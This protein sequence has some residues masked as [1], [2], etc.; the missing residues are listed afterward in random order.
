MIDKRILAQVVPKS[1]MS[2]HFIQQQSWI[3]DIVLNQA[4]TTT[5]FAD[6]LVQFAKAL[7][8]TDYHADTISLLICTHVFKWA[9]NGFTDPDDRKLKTVQVMYAV[10]LEW[11]MQIS[12]KVGRGKPEA[13]KV[14]TSLSNIL[15]LV[16]IHKHIK[17]R[18]FIRVMCRSMGANIQ[19]SFLTHQYSNKDWVC[20]CKH[21]FNSVWRSEHMSTKHSSTVQSCVYLVWSHE[22]MVF[23]IGKAN[24]DR[25][26]GLPGIVARFKEHM[27]AT[28][29][30]TESAKPAKRYQVWKNAKHASMLCT[31]VVWGQEKQILA[32]ERHLIHALNISIQDRVQPVAFQPH[33]YRP[34]PRFRTRWSIEQELCLNQCSFLGKDK[35]QTKEFRHGVPMHIQ[36]FEQLVVWCRHTYNLSKRSCHQALVQL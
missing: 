32:Y 4:L 33:K 35:R 1:V 20:F 10:V 15:A 13:W 28:F 17:H 11:L 7:H 16:N 9:C 3:S 36:S 6:I 34:Y 14:L 31:P 30:S 29:K 27:L 19:K 26:H 18:P 2:N 22:Q 24:L 5:K 21:V 12:L 23:Y 25:E 8:I